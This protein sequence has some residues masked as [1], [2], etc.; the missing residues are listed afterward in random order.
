MSRKIFIWLNKMINFSERQC[1]RNLDW[2]N[3]LCWI[4]CIFYKLDST[5][6]L[7]APWFCLVILPKYDLIYLV[8][9]PNAT[10]ICNQKKKKKASRN[11]E[12]PNW[13]LGSSVINQFIMFD[14][15]SA[16]YTYIL[17]PHGRRI[18]CMHIMK[19]KKRHAYLLSNLVV[20]FCSFK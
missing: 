12:A 17:L 19:K 13:W 6:L 4:C 2:V 3:K 10:L 1:F 7:K 5:I 9:H 8:R 14:N 11:I 20:I 18:I 15:K 16:S